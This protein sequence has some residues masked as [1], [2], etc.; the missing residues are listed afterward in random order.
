MVPRLDAD[1][2]VDALAVHVPAGRVPVRAAARGEPARRSKLEPEFELVDTGIFDDGR[3]WEITADYAKAGAGG[4]PASPHASATPGPEA[5][6]IDVL[7]TLWFRN[8]WSWGDDAAKPSIS[9]R[10]RQ[11]RRRARRSWARRFLCEQRVAAGRS[12]A[13]TRRTGSLFGSAESPPYPKDGINDHV[14]TAPRR[15][16][17]SRPGPRQRSTTAS[18][19][20]PARP[21]RSSSASATSDAGL[22]ADFARDPRRRE[23]GGRRVLRRAHARRLR[24][25]RGARPP[26]GAR[27]DALVEAVLPLRR[28]R[29][30]DGDPRSRRRRPSARPGRNSRLAAPQQPRRDLDARHVGVPVVRGVG[31]RVPL[32]RAR[33]RRPGVREGAAAPARPRVVHAPER[34]AARVRVGVRRRQPAGARVGGAARLRD[35]RLDATSTS[36]SASSTSCSS[37]SPGG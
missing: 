4:H 31:P 10:R 6:T 15:S 34:A 32:R 12:S 27:R 9:L 21:R 22:G 20:P 5:A 37:T 16:T 19:S 17:R 29:W 1:P 7:P 8:T 11:A 36:S 18:R 14:R 30:L 23:R 3:Y 28:R 35:R 2:L 26:P 25:G 13:T 33:A 24:R